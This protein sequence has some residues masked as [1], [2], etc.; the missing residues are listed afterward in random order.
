M[1]R[2]LLYGRRTHL[3]DGDASSMAIRCLSSHFEIYLCPQQPQTCATTPLFAIFRKVGSDCISKAMIL[4]ED[5][6]RRLQ[7]SLHTYPGSSRLKMAFVRRRD[8]PRGSAAA[9]LGSGA[10]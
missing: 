1:R 5:A 6:V 9:E 7:F 8:I 3:R 4:I 2:A 10:E